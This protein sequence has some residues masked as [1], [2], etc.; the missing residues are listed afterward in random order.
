[1]SQKDFQKLEKALM[2]YNTY[3]AIFLEIKSAIGVVEGVDNSMSE[4]DMSIGGGT[5]SFSLYNTGFHQFNGELFPKTLDAHSY[6]PEAKL[7]SADVNSFATA[8]F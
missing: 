2:V 1:M 5:E 6:I 8:L 3:Q 7:F 4:S